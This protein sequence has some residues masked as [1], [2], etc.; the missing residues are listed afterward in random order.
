MAEQ[1][2]TG[3]KSFVIEG[4]VERL[5]KRNNNQNTGEATQAF[6]V[7][8]WGGNDYVRV[9]QSQAGLV[10]VGAWLKMLAPVIEITDRETNSTNTF[11]GTARI[12][13]VDGKPVS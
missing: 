4:S 8:Y 11:A 1:M 10:K 7:T 12:V 13:E 6:T 5:G 3:G 9:D 2:K